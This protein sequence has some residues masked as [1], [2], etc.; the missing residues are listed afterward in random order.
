MRTARVFDNKVGSILLTV[1]SVF[2]P[3]IWKVMV[4]TAYPFFL[5]ASK[6]FEAL[7]RKGTIGAFIADTGFVPMLIAYTA[8]IFILK[9][10]RI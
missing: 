8:L 1:R 3:R 9:K 4:L 7:E 2:T 10:R 6:Y 5:L